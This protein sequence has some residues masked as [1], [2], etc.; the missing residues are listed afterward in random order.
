[1]AASF[2]SLQGGFGTGEATAEDVNLLH[3][4]EFFSD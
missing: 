1:L 4:I 2:G 3:G